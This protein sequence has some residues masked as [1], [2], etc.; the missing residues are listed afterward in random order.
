MQISNHKDFNA[1]L[2]FIL[3]GISTTVLA[4]SYPIGTAAKMGP[5]YFPFIL[6]FMLTVLGFVISLKSLSK[7]RGVRKRALI[8][9]RP[10]V[11][12]LSSIVLFG[13]LL[14]PLG[15]LLSTLLLILIS[16]MASDEFKMKVAILNAFVLLIV[17]LIIFV[18]FLQFQIP[19]LPAFLGGRT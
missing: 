5:G 12:V 15:L 6:G 9:F 11:F 2:L 18:Y 17:V 8:R 10:V 16:S 4:R 3:L 14:L 1:G 13:L 7:R 19:V